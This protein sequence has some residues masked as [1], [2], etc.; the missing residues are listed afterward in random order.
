MSEVLIATLLGATAL[1]FLWCVWSLICNEITYR[2]RM[3]IIDLMSSERLYPDYCKVTYDQHM[4]ALQLL[5]DPMALYSVKV[6]V[7]LAK[8]AIRTPSTPKRA[9]T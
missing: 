5:R 2:Q 6:R 3:R 4:R 7:A 9:D 8:D 1:A